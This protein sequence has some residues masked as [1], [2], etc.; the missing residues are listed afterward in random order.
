MKIS[1]ITVSYNSD[2]T[3]E[4]TLRSVSAQTYSNIEHI[5]VDGGS[6]DKTLEIISKYPHVSTLVSEPDEGI[7]DAMEKGVRLAT[8]DVIGVLNSDDLFSSCTIIEEI[9]KVFMRSV[10]S[11]IVYGTVK[12]FK[13]D[14]PKAIVRNMTTVPYYDTFFEDGEVPPHE[15]FY[16]KREVYDSIEGYDKSF[17]IA[18]DYDFM[19]RALKIKGYK[20]EFLDKTIVLMRM[21]GASSSGDF[22]SYVLAS[23]EVFRV[24]KKNKVKYPVKLFFLRPIK[25]ILQV[26]S[27]N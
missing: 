16:A 12:Y 6:T 14:D 20:S 10:H 2:K 25:K 9:S 24:W 22:G 15:A 23:S 27:S 26:L 7:Y 17:K 4:E 3:I 13:E 5:I 8:G 19:F 18:G 21:G 1:I 11:K